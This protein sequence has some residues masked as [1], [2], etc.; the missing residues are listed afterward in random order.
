MIHK[1]GGADCN[2]C[3]MLLDA[4]R[5]GIFRAVT[6]ATESKLPGYVW[7]DKEQLKGAIPR[8]P[9]PVEAATLIPMPPPARQSRRGVLS[10]CLSRHPFGSSGCSPAAARIACPSSSAVKVISWE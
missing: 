8:F 3:A 9:T 5:A 2:Y 4:P 10:H 7:Q 6:R 1:S